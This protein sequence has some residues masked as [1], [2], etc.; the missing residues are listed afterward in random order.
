MAARPPTEHGEN[1]VRA[2]YVIGGSLLLAALITWSVLWVQRAVPLTRWAPLQFFSGSL[3]GVLLALTIGY[4]VRTAVLKRKPNRPLLTTTVLLGVGYAVT[5]W[6]GLVGRGGG[7]PL[8]LLLTAT[9]AAAM[10][11]GALLGF[12]FGLPRFDYGARSGT[13]NATSAQESTASSVPPPTIA[14]TTSVTRYRPS[15]NLDD[16]ADWLTKI[17]VGLGLTQITTVGTAL[18]QASKTILTPCGPDCLAREGFTS[19]IIVSGAVGGFLFAYI[20]TRLYY[21]AMAA[22]SDKEV[23]REIEESSTEKLGIGHPP[24]K[25]PREHGERG[26]E[27][28]PPESVEE[29]K[30]L[31][32]RVDSSDADPNKGKFGGSALQNDRALRAIIEPAVTMPGFYRVTMTVSSALPTKPLTGEV[33]LHL[34]PTFRQSVVTVPVTNGVASLT[35][36]SYGAFTVGAVCDNGKTLLELDLAVLPDAPQDFKSR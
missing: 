6:Q 22:K 14:T 2:A 8:A 4:V 36:I 1:T 23:M 33:E 3:G 34:H 11:I 20:W 9:M 25:T 21:A 5:F 7:L 24:T 15:T 26:P 35:V 31:T 19:A 32:D 27:G 18:S 30:R 12:L 17:I 13:Q 29:K 10:A 16:V 28:A